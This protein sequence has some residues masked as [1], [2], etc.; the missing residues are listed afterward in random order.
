MSKNTHYY[1]R[2]ISWDVITE[3]EY[4][5]LPNKAKENYKYYGNAPIGKFDTK[6]R[7]YYLIDIQTN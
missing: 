4:N 7:K 3:H 1:R 2:L 6:N 5:N